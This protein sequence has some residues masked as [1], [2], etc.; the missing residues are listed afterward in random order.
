[1]RILVRQFVEAE[2]AAVG[3]RDATR[4]G[5][6][7]EPEQPRHLFGRLEVAIGVALAPEPDVVDDDAFADAGDDVLQDAATG[8]VEQ[9]V[10]GGDGGDAKAG[11]EV[12]EV[13]QA[14]MVA[15]PATQGQ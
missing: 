4:D 10:V 1:M 3:D 13:V 9:H 12:A 11:G 2:P 6:G 7:P 5:L 14:Q 15:G 8:D